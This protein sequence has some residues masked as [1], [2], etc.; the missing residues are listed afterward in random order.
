MFDL[1]SSLKYRMKS[2][3]VTAE[4]AL[5]GRSQAMTLN[6]RHFVLGMPLL[7]PYPAGMETLIV[8][9][10]C[11]WGAEKRFW[12]L[13][14]VYTTAV[15]YSAG[16]TPNPDYEEVCSGQ[17]GH[18]EVVKVVFDPRQVK[19]E[20]LLRVF[21]ESHDP[22]QGMRQGND[23]GTQYRSG[24]YYTDNEQLKIIEK[25]MQHFQQQLSRHGAGNIT[26]EIFQATPF[27]SANDHP[28]QKFA[29]NPGGY[30][31]LGGT[32]VCY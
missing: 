9:M 16:F 28:Q 4:E 2:R 12:G 3:M 21:W 15:G 8:G 13:S 14:G 18:N 27:Y 5:P 30:C 31:G 25:S 22:T 11:F 17:T 19:L 23:M 20:D 10:G 6:N 24:I 1:Y 26:T 29:K 32:G 7:P